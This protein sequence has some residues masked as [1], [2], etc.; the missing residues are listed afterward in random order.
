MSNAITDPLTGLYTRFYLQEFVPKLFALHQRD[1]EL[2]VAVALL[3]LDH[4]K[5]IN[6]NY[7]HSAGDRVLSMTGKLIKGIIRKGDIAVRYGGEEILLILPCINPG[8]VEGLLERIRY[9]IEKSKVDW[10][11]NNISVTVS[12]GIAFAG[13][14]SMFEAINRADEKLYKAK[15][16]GRNKIIF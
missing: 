4:F 2:Q 7:G 13:D 14:E 12:G 1:P 8:D 16:S 9:S 11:D 10:E 6:D 5:K 15:H 3:D